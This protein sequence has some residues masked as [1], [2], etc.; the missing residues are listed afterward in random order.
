MTN[1]DICSE[2]SVSGDG[3]TRTLTPLLAPDPKSGVSTFHHT[4]IN[5]GFIHLKET[6]ETLTKN[7]Q[8]PQSPLCNPPPKKLLTHYLYLGDQWGSNPRHSEPQSDAL[9]TELWSPYFERHGRIEL[10]SPAWQAG[11]IT[12]IRIPQTLQSQAC[13]TPQT[14]DS[15]SEDKAQL[16]YDSF[17]KDHLLYL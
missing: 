10:P 7:L 8:D 16:R 14:Y 13:S 11:I 1:Q 2:S 3:E 15:V 4:P 9:P 12:V 5:P 6:K 17:V